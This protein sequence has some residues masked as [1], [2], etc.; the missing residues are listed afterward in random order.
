MKGG[1]VPVISIFL[2]IIVRIYY[3]DHNP[4]HFHAQYGDYEVIVE[5][6]TGKVLNGKL[7]KRLMFLLESWRK[8][9]VAEILQSWNDAQCFKVPGRIKPLE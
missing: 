7:P 9:N 8:E 6:R 3:A 5:I 2:G 1:R 4:P